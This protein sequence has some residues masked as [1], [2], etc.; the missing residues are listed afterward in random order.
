MSSGY[1]G[2][3]FSY[4]LAVFKLRQPFSG[5]WSFIDNIHLNWTQF[6]LSSAYFYSVWIMLAAAALPLLKSEGRIGTNEF[7][8][9]SIL[10]IATWLQAYFAGLMTWGRL[11]A[12]FSFA[13]FGLGAYLSLRMLS[14]FVPNEKRL[15]SGIIVIWLLWGIFTIAEF[16]WIH[17]YEQLKGEAALKELNEYQQ[18]KANNL[19]F[20]D[21]NI[22]VH[23]W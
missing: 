19:M 9:L 16:P 15:M 10:I 5:F 13:V 23:P 12:D 17:P 7:A 1:S 6:M 20:I 21:K 18:R 14:H 4:H 3:E 8:F 2:G 11:M 22:V